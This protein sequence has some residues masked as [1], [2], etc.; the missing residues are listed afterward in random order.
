MIGWENDQR[1]VCPSLVVGWGSKF[2]CCQSGKRQPPSS[3]H[4]VFFLFVFFSWCVSLYSVWNH[5]THICHL[6]FCIWKFSVLCDCHFTS[7]CTYGWTHIPFI[8]IHHI[9]LMMTQN[10]YE[11]QEHSLGDMTLAFFPPTTFPTSICFSSP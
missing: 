11:V 2:E 1:T 4:S 8:D 7:I 5:S 9:G 3:Q 10:F 6:C